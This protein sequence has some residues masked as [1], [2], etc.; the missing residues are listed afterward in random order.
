MSLA[1]L[2]KSRSTCMA[3]LDQILEYRLSKNRWR[4]ST[5]LLARVESMKFRRRIIRIK[6]QIL[7]SMILGPQV[8]YWSLLRRKYTFYQS[9]TVPFVIAV[10]WTPC[11]TVPLFAPVAVFLAQ[12]HEL[13]DRGALVCFKK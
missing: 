7:Q 3:R 1:Q 2:N 10:Q 12:L 4:N 9:A 5:A 6:I 13:T 8:F 11:T